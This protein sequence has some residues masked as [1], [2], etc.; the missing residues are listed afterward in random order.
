MK[1][2]SWNVNGIRAMVKKG[3]YDTVKELNADIFCV[4]ETKAPDDVLKDIGS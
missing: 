2:I 3:L 4:Q 1:L